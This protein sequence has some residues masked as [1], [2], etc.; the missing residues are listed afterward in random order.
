[1]ALLRPNDLTFNYKVNLSNAVTR[2]VYGIVDSI[3]SYTDACVRDYFCI[4]TV[5]VPGGQTVQVSN[6]DSPREDSDD[7]WIDVVADNP[8]FCII[9]YPITWLRIKGVPTDKKG[10]RAYVISA[11]RSDND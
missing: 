7:D 4:H 1:M 5:H 9:Q 8:K 2:D 10:V 3:L 6:I 11:V